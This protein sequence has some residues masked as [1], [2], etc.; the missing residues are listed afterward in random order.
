LAYGACHL[1]SSPGWHS[2]DCAT[3]RPRGGWRQRLRQRCLGEG[4]QLLAPQASQGATERFRLRTEAM[5]S[6]QLQL[7]VI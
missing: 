3:W 5:G 6:V 1:P 7:G 2:L 4:L